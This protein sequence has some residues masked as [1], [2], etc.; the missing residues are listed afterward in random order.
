MIKCR[1]S[2]MTNIGT[3]QVAEVT[4]GYCMFPKEPLD[5]HP[6]MADTV[7]QKQGEPLRGKVPPNF[8]IGGVAYRII[9]FLWD[10]A[11]IP[12]DKPAANEE[13]QEALL[14]I[15]VQKLQM[16]SIVQAPAAVLDVLKASGARP[17]KLS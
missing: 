15:A 9:G 16:S 14:V 3:P 1:I 6:D 7:P 2:E 5:L 8:L 13:W 17:G 4:I 12:L 11:P 10:V